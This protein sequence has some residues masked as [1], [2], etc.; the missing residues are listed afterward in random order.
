MMEF[1]TCA[2][3]VTLI[4]S[5]IAHPYGYGVKGGAGASA[6]AISGAS[7]GSYGGLGDVP[8]GNGFSGSF[9]KSSSSSSSSASS[10]SS[11]SSS[12]FTYSGSG[13]FSG[14]GTNDNT[15]CTTGACQNAEA[16]G[17]GV[18][19]FSDLGTNGNTGCTTG[20]CQNS[21]AKDISVNFGAAG[22]GAGI[23]GFNAAT[24]ADSKSDCQGPTC[25][26]SGKCSSGACLSKSET[27]SSPTGQDANQKCTSGQCGSTT[28]LNPS[29]AQDNDSD[30]I[31]FVSHS[32]NSAHDTQAQ[33]ADTDKTTAYNAGFKCHGSSCD[34][35][36]AINPQL[37]S[38]P[39]SNQQPN[40]VISGVTPGYHLPSIHLET[41][42]QDSNC[43]S[44]KCDTEYSR[45]GFENSLSSYNVPIH[46]SYD[47]N[48]QK[49]QCEDGKCDRPQ[50]GSY[51]TTSNSLPSNYLTP[52]NSQAT[53]GPS[54]PSVATCTGSN[55]GS[56][57]SGQIGNTPSN[58][59]SNN[60]QIGLSASNAG[61]FGCN[62]PNC[63]PKYA[64]SAPTGPSV[65]IN[66][67]NH[68]Q[69]IDKYQTPNQQ[70]AYTGGFGA[71]TGV[72]TSTNSNP[73]HPSTSLHKEPQFGSAVGCS[74]PNC[75][76]QGSLPA[77]T[78]YDGTKP[79]GNVNLPTYTGGFGGP[80][81]TLKPNENNF[82]TSV[83][84]KPIQPVHP[85]HNTPAIITGCKTA[86][87]FGS[88]TAAGSTASSS[89]SGTY[90]INKQ[91]EENVYTG[92]FGGPSGMLKPNEFD[93]KVTNKPTQSATKPNI[94]VES[95]SELPL[96]TGSFGGPAGLLKPNEF[97]ITQISPNGRYPNQSG[98][99]PNPADC[100]TANCSPSSNI[101][102]GI[103]A[104]PQST[105]TT[106]KPITLSPHGYTS[107]YVRP[108]GVTYPSNLPVAPI[109][110][111]YASPLHPIGTYSVGCKTANCAP[112]PINGLT[113]GPNPQSSNPINAAGSPPSDLQSSNSPSGSGFNHPLIPS[114]DSHNLPSTLTSSKCQSPD[115]T[116]LGTTGADVVAQ[117][118]SYAGSKQTIPV[119]TGGFG[120]PSGLLKPQDESISAGNSKPNELIKPT[121]T[122]LSAA[123]T[124]GF[125]NPK[126]TAP[127]STGFGVASSGAQASASSSAS[128]N[129]VAYTGGFDGPPGILKPFDYTKVD[130]TK[131]LGAKD[132]GVQFDV[133][134]IHSS[135][136][137]KPGTVVGGSALNA[138]TTGHPLPQVDP[139][140][141]SGST[142]GAA[143]FS[144]S[145]ASSNVGSYGY[146][147]HGTHPTGYSV[148]GSSPCGG[149]CGGYQGGLTGSGSLAAAGARSLSSA[150][151]FGLGGA[152][153][154]SSA[155]AHASSGAYTKGGYGKR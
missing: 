9:T 75:F 31:H 76:G 1:K 12:S 81:G 98:I 3:I 4:S 22:T 73:I 94:I 77:Q 32:L 82:P 152:F 5:V 71:P 141:L 65:Q 102:T 117:S 92:G 88:S 146:S 134:N 148:K 143:A 115:C 70:P 130:L 41:P 116:I 15:G 101:G 44:G 155:S 68:A 132:S 78:D 48:A 55:C 33:A 108:V 87:C 127:S 107:N 91:S 21:G 45:P 84:G 36:T 29:T 49:A 149:G 135:Y 56:E 60:H 124:S 126:V 67:I 119:Y 51:S 13:S 118:G 10:S 153:A 122:S 89:Q 59:G 52:Q 17:S 46:G 109:T 140:A 138:D 39:S 154:S 35:S 147:N 111:N 64:L 38:N 103:V 11:S 69:P 97:D 74:S 26:D 129:A 24:V 120:A 96:Y 63:S 104:N 61:S 145:A 99:S 121:S 142:A 93:I 50:K 19:S 95:S 62:T 54:Y 110:P 72:L 133:T 150:N 18:S 14:L 112:S 25:I 136:N 83:L 37:D 80:A 6:K 66:Q 137:V 40:A 20:A 2:L 114:P 139:V 151:S 125:C 16:S 47:T 144:G 43:K 58:T 30:D 90:N 85:T 28:Q 86:N 128:A 105:F 113:T 79:N 100:F 8:F 34:P 7:A 57:P 123:C 42:K 131:L 27:V 106:P 53:T 23:Y